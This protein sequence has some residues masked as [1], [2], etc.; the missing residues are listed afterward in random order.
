MVIVK[1]CSLDLTLDS[2]L[3][4]ASDDT[5]HKSYSLPRRKLK[6]ILYID[7][8]FPLVDSLQNESNIGKDW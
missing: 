1:V 6:S 8:G 3:F 5:T 7:Q 4:H 2:G